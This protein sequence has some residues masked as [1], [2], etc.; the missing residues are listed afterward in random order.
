MARM[1][2]RQRG[3]FGAAWALAFVAE[4]ARG[5][6]EAVS[7]ASPAGEFGIVHARRD[8]TQPHFDD[9]GRTAV[10]PIFHVI[11]GMAAAAGAPRVET[12]ASDPAR[13]APVAYGREGQTV[14]WLANLRPEP[15]QVTLE[16]VRGGQVQMLDEESFEAATADPAGFSA[17]SRPLKGGRVTLGAYAVA[18][19]EAPA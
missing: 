1:E 13:V 15:Q 8:W 17:G 4:A 14:L 18:R 11:A 19:I 9:L 16:G 7:L 10:F 3:L 5:G 2:P 6:L 12:E